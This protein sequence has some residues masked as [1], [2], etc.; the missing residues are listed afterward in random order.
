MRIKMGGEDRY[1][2]GG[3]GQEGHQQTISKQELEAL[4][5]N[6]HYILEQ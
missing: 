5:N 1:R 2:G 4:E 6:K 3:S